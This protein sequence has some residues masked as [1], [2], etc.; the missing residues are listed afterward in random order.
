MCA[1]PTTGVATLAGCVIGV[2]GK[3][4]DS[5]FRSYDL[6]MVVFSKCPNFN[7]ALILAVSVP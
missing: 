3:T 5:R 6:H 7:S 2:A 4:R 1:E